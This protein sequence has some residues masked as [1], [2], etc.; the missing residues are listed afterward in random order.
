MRHCLSGPCLRLWEPVSLSCPDIWVRKPD[1]LHL[2]YTGEPSLGFKP[3]TSQGDL[4]GHWNIH[5]ALQLLPVG[6][7]PARSLSSALCTSPI[8]VQLFLLSVVIRLLPRYCSVVYSGWFLHNLVIIPD[9]SR[10]EVSVASTYSC[11]ILD[12]SAVFILFFKIFYLFLERGEGTE[13]ERE[14]E[15][16]MCV[17]LSCAPHWGPGLQPRNVPWLGIT[18]ATLCFTVWCSIHWATPARA[19]C[20]F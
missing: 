18:L 10:K 15:T 14:R 16:S 8:V 12:L 19:Q 4:P 1:W 20:C 3:H 9:W 7:Q 5:L 6:A 13:K 11:A 2:P 17:C